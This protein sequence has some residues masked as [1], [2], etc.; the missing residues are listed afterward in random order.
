MGISRVRI[1]L[2]K[3]A[4]E[5]IES[6]IAEKEEQFAYRKQAQA[7]FNKLITAANSVDNDVDDAKVK[8]LEEQREIAL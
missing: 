1:Q 5:K 4:N 8:K 7:R 6:Y 3:D 2:I